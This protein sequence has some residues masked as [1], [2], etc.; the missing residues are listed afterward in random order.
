MGG[1]PGLNFGYAV[2]P[3]LSTPYGATMEPEHPSVK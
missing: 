3:D 2:D 1:F